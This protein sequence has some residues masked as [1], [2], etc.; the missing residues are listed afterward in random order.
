MH[1][2]SRY[3]LRVVFVSAC[4]W[5]A[6]AC[7]SGS[8]PSNVGNNVNRVPIA[9]PL[10]MNSGATNAVREGAEVLLTGRDSEDPDGPLLD[11]RW[12]GPAGVPLVTRS[13]TTVSFTAPDV[14]VETAF[15][16]ELTVFDTDGAT[17]TAPIQVVVVPADD[18]NTFLAPRAVQG[19]APDVVTFVAAL[20]PGT[21]VG[22]IDVPFSIRL[23]AAL[24][25]QARG[26]FAETVPLDLPELAEPLVGVWPANETMTCAQGQSAEDCMRSSFL[27]SRFAVQVPRL[28]ATDFNAQFFASGELSRL[29]DPHLVEFATVEITATLDAGNLQPNA[30]LLV[31]GDSAVI[32]QAGPSQIGIPAELTVTNDTLLGGVSGEEQ[33]ATAEAYYRTVDPYSRRQRLSDWLIMAGFAGPDGRLLPEAE[34]GTGE[35]AH[36]LYTNNFDLG[37]GRDMYVRTAPNG[38]VF[39]FVANYPTLEAGIKKTDSF[40]TVVMEFTPPDN[41]SLHASCAVK[42][43]FVKFFT[44][45]PDERGD[46]QRVTAMNFDGRGERYTPG[47]CVTCHGGTFGN[48]SDTVPDPAGGLPL[49]RDCGDTNATFMPWDLD[50]FLY[51]DTDPAIVSGAPRPDG[52]SFVDYTDPTGRFR[53][54]A[55]EEQ[56]RKL[57]VA[58]LGT[59]ETYVAEGGDAARMATAI[60]LVN[61]WYGGTPRTP[62][63]RFDGSFTPAGWDVSDDVAHAYHVAFARHCRA[64][65]VQL[66]DPNKHFASYRDFVVNPLTGNARA[67]E[68]LVYRRG[69][70]PLARLSMDRFWVPFEGGTPPAVVLAEVLAAD[71]DI[72]LDPEARPGAPVFDIVRSPDTPKETDIVRL[73]ARR[74]AFVSDPQ[75]RALDATANGVCVVPTLI[76]ATTLDVAFRA[77]RPGRYC[78]ELESN[79]VTTVEEFEVAANSPPTLVVHAFAQTIDEN[80]S[81]QPIELAYEDLDDTPDELVYTLRGTLNGTVFLDGVPLI[82]GGQFTQAAIE[83]GQVTFDPG[84][85]G[86]LMAGELVDGGFDY[87]ITDGL[88][89]LGA[90][91]AAALQYRLNIRGVNDGQPTVTVSNSPASALFV[92][93]TVALGSARIS[94]ADPDTSAS[95]L[96]I[97]VQMAPGSSGSISPAQLTY[98]QIL[99][100]MSFQYQHNGS[101]DFVDTVNVRVTDGTFTS[102]VSALMVSSR[103]SFANNIGGVVSAQ[104]TGILGGNCALN[105]HNATGGGVGAPNFTSGGSVSYTAV[106]SRVS[107]PENACASPNSPSSLLLAKPSQSVAHTGGLQ[108]GFDL[109]QG[110]DRSAYNLVRAWICSFGAGNN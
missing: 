86:N 46:S 93:G 28:D 51:S 108:P 34:Q 42:Q 14:D 84:Y 54:D 78:I 57:N 68:D 91:P 95:G 85:A 35:F 89:T 33:R 6:Q 8:G 19:T 1:S 83:A 4:A 21:S 73:D 5:L 30:H 80:A 64:C 58:S 109:S 50:S 47:N 104:S 24:T 22:V 41:P 59:Y 27:S 7:S 77:S 110:G 76:A 72:Q 38:D 18:L 3:A 39:A 43:R 107:L 66:A 44:Y 100:G 29:L 52:K 16:F 106:S 87:A 45:V 61:G 90:A 23:S 40:A 49:F 20:E 92:G 56:F 15:N 25:Y 88:A 71:P 10:I 26:N 97:T 99:N 62:G 11:W 9:R 53:R 48:L 79:G 98:Q 13:R 36:A 96:T 67:L 81:P 31:T 12:S 75:W 63:T 82:V 70:M 65:H 32:A 17:H 55:Q 60:E 103:V 74:S 94:A 2:I 37:F 69:I 105:C 102:G 101:L